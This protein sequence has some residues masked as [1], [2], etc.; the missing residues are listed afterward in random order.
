MNKV[1]VA[2][3][4]L[5]LGVS[6][7]T[8]KARIRNGQLQAIKTK[9]YRNKA[10]WLVLFQ[11]EESG[12]W[13][14]LLK[15]YENFCCRYRHN[16]KRLSHNTI[17]TN[18]FGLE[19]FFRVLNLEPSLSAITVENLLHFYET[20]GQKP[21]K[22]FHAQKANTQRALV[23]FLKFIVSKNSS[24]QKLLEAIQ[25]LRP[26]RLSPVKRRRLYG[27]SFQRFF[28]GEG[29]EFQDD[30]YQAR[31]RVLLGLATF[32]GLRLNEIATITWPC[33][34]ENFE[35]AEFIGKGEKQRIVYVPKHF[36]KTLA[37]FKET[38][39]SSSDLRVLQASRSAIQSA[40]RLY[41]NHT[42]VDIHLHGLRYTYATNLLEAGTPITAVQ[43]LLGH[44]DITTT[45]LYCEYSNDHLIHLM[46][47]R[48]A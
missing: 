25:V 47:Q 26:K 1:T 2:Q 42:G 8:V 21:G 36:R 11:G 38:S 44:S 16:L 3:A 22:C 39:A 12:E 10:V 46:N 41:R 27:E 34:T 28:K 35:Y 6:E 40:F 14:E 20:L 19:R 33:F 48:D 15:N 24:Y 31:M 32:M 13:A 18:R 4:A 5:M 29:Y 7:S 9:G 37:A 17:K 23:H 30:F 45:Q 43:K